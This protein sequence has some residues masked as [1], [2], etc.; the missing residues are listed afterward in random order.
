[1]YYLTKNGNFIFKNTKHNVKKYIT[2]LITDTHMH[3]LGFGEKLLNPDLEKLNTEQIQKIIIDKLNKGEDKVILRGWSNLKMDLDPISKNIPII[4]IRRCGHIAIVNSIIL[5]K[6]SKE[7]DNKYIDFK[8]KI[9]KE[10]ALEKFYE[11]YGYFSDIKG[12]YKKATKYLQSK[13]YGYVHSDDLHGIKKENLPFNNEMKILE[14]VAINNFDELRNY[15]NLKYFEKF[16]SVKLY[17]DGSFGGRTA[18]LREKYNDSKEN[19]SILWH[20]EELKK[21]IEFCENHNLHLCMH[22]IGDKAVDIILESFNDLKPNNFHRIIHASILHDEQIK[23]IKKHKLILDMQPQFFD[24]D[25]EILESRLG[26]RKKL[27]YRFKDLYN[28]KIPMFFSSDA[29]VEMPDWIRDA[30]I[31]NNLGLPLNYIIYNLTYFPEFIDGFDRE[32]QFLIFKENPFEKLTIPYI[33]GKN[34]I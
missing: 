10:K 34:D 25:K 9:I 29:P 21:V 5:E 2:P 24:S 28:E 22:A 3:I 16:K 20:K 15:Y 14:K 6:L 7:I 12:A 27:T 32:K 26:K 19:G 13:G 31:L 23:M 33:G 4:L 30:R 1:M 17:M 8:N 11:I 18:F